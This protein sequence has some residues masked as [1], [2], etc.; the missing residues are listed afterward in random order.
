M[1]LT[2]EEYSKIACKNYLKT[3][4]YSIVINNFSTI[5]IFKH[6]KTIVCKKQKKSNSL[7]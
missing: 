3:L 7:L 2:L 6:R 1:I 5:N 4:N